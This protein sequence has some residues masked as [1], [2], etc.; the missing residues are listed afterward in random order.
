MVANEDDRKELQDIIHNSKLSEG[1]L[2]LAHDIGVMEFKT[3]EDVYK[4][5]GLCIKKKYL[6]PN[7]KQ[8][9]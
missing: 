9:G 7:C 6:K 1:Y 3:P 5:C 8:E 4:V 2:Y